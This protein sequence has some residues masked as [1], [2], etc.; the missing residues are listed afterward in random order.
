VTRKQKKIKKNKEQKLTP[1]LLRCG[2]RVDRWCM[3]HQGK[4][5]H[6]VS[7]TEIPCKPLMR[8]LFLKRN[9][10]T[11]RALAHLAGLREKAITRK[12]K[13]R[14]NREA[15]SFKE[16]SVDSSPASVCRDCF[17]FLLCEIP[18]PRVEINFATSSTIMTGKWYSPLQPGQSNG[19]VRQNKLLSAP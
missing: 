4:L 16:V 13:A 1:R 7:I 2:R 11:Q 17:P 8:N 18:M 14:H 3:K 5:Q 10:T 6:G 9:V 15:A 19:A 12:R